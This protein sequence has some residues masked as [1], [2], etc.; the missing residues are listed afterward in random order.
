MLCY[1][2]LCYASFKAAVWLHAVPAENLSL[3]IAGRQ[4]VVASIV[5]RAT[6]ESQSNSG[7]DQRQA[8]DLVTDHGQQSVKAQGDL[9]S[10]LSA[11]SGH[12]SSQ[13]S[14]LL[15]KSKVMPRHSKQDAVAQ[16]GHHGAEVVRGQGISHPQ[17]AQRVPGPQHAEHR[18]RSQHAQHSMQAGFTATVSMTARCTQQSP[19]SWNSNSS[20][21]SHCSATVHSPEATSS[22]SIHAS[23]SPRRQSK[24]VKHGRQEELAKQSATVTAQRECVPAQLPEQL[25]E[26]LPKQSSRVRGQHESGSAQIQLLPMHTSPYGAPFPTH[27]S[28]RLQE[29]LPDTTAPPQAGASNHVQQP[30]PLIASAKS[31]SRAASIVA[32]QQQAAS[33][34]SS[35]ASPGLSRQAS[36]Y[37]VPQGATGPGNAQLAASQGQM[38]QQAQQAASQ[39]QMAALPRSDNASS[40]RCGAPNERTASQPKPVAVPRSHSVSSARHVVP[41]GDSCQAQ[42]EQQT[43]SEVCGPASRQRL[44]PK[45]QQ[46][47]LQNEVSTSSTQRPQLQKHVSTGCT[48]QPQLQKHVSTVSTQRPELQEQMSIGSTQRPQLQTHVSTVSTQRPEL[49]EQ[50][51]TGSTQRPQLQKNIRSDSASSSMQLGSQLDLQEVSQPDCS[52]S[53]RH[54]LSHS[55]HSAQQEVSQPDCSSSSRHA[56]FKPSY[57]AQRDQDALQPRYSAQQSLQPQC[58]GSHGVLR[59]EGLALLQERSQL[60]LATQ[61]SYSELSRQGL[62]EDNCRLRQALAAIE[63]QLGMIRNQQVTDLLPSICSHLSVPF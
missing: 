23:L 61:G 50:M 9:S 54:T 31:L 35:T 62:E 30:V 10:S 40:A 5:P 20:I 6:R 45:T 34:S 4:T 16:H 15:T 43:E 26:Q 44:L 47:Q 48:Q 14:S 52:S 12:K 55:S 53:S 18:Q 27:I 21:V 7:R 56:L 25:L 13:A 28:A 32:A 36:Q 29:D 49:Q 57:S 2:K 11:E 60:A 42:S 3:L 17:H 51:S 24:A 38:A 41:N 59:A 58:S 8:A 63:R 22:L 37:G 33:R 1:A 46:S 19:E 39:G